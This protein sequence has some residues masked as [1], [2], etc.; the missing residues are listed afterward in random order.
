MIACTYCTRGTSNHAQ[1]TPASALNEDMGLW[2]RM[3]HTN[4]ASS[5]RN[6]ACLEWCEGRSENSEAGAK[7]EGEEGCASL[8]FWRE[9]SGRVK[10]TTRLLGGRRMLRSTLPS[11]YTIDRMVDGVTGLTL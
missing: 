4:D 8:E 10:S 6:P 9:S 11:S 2:E 7:G 5:I 1:T 3:A